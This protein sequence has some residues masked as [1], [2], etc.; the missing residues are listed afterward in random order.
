LIDGL[1]G[2]AWV[3]DGAPRA[4]FVFTIAAGKIAA[5]DIVMDLAHLGEL[6]V[7]LLDG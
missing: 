2:A 7:V 3:V 1:P 4:A 5:I 6:D